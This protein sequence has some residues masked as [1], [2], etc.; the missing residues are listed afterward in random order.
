MERSHILYWIW[1]SLCFVPGSRNADLLLEHFGENAKSIF[2]ADDAE[3][4]RLDLTES[5][6]K[7][8][9]SKDSAEAK[10]IYYWCREHGVRLLAYDDPAFPDRLRH[11][12]HRPVLLY[13][14]GREI[15]LPNNLMIAMVGT[16]RISSY[17][18]RTAYAISYDLARAGAVVVSGMALGVDAVCHGAALD[19]MGDTVAILGCG[20]D[21]AYPKQNPHR[22]QAGNA[23]D[24]RELSRAQPAD[25]RHFAG[26]AGGRSRRAERRNDHRASRQGAGAGSFRPAR[27]G[28][29]AEQ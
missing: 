2:E 27:N 26:N 15:D 8:L 12:A 1:L 5:V 19:A 17:G 11:I 25:Q 10:R 4:D 20:I 16:R 18:S 29:R 13:A 21:I 14:S 28:G 22:V 23:P 3:Y 24:A 6:K 9:R 7:R